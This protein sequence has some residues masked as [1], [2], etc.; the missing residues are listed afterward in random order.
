[1]IK[2]TGA[3]K[4]RPVFNASA[5]KPG[6]PSLNQCLK[7]GPNLIEL[8]SASL[9]RFREG[10]IGIISDIKPAFLQVVVDK[11]DRDMLCFL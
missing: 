2:E 4:I 9:N 1:M 11:V 10:K 7:V 6:C 3:T 5:S 8:N